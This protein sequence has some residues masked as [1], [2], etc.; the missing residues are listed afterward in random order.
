MTHEYPDD[1]TFTKSEIEDILNNTV[2]KTLIEV[3]SRNVFERTKAHPKI[4]GIA[5][6]VIERSVLGYRSNSKKA[7]DILIDG[8][9]T[10][11]K[12]TGIVIDPESKGKKEM[13]IA[14]EPM[15]ITAVSLKTIGSQEFLSSPFYEKIDHMLIVYY[16]YTS[17]P[18]G[19]TQ[20]SDYADFP[21]KGY[22][23]HEFGD[24]DIRKIEH[25]WT[26][27]RDF[28]RTIDETCEN[29][30]E[31]YPRLSSELRGSLLCLDTAPKWP[32]PPRF[33]FK[34]AFVTDMVKQHFGG[35]RSE[36][37]LEDFR[38]MNELEALCHA[39]SERYRGMTI[40][41]LVNELN[42]NVNR[43]R[44]SVSEQIII[45]MLGGGV[46]KMRDVDILGRYSIVP[47]SIVLNPNGGST[48]STKL[49]SIDFD[50]FL[51][52]HTQFQDSEVFD[53]FI[54]NSFLAIVFQE[55]EKDSL[56]DS[57]FLGFKKIVFPMSFIKRQVRRTWKD[58]RRIV[59]NGHLRET[60]RRKKDGS[61]IINKNGTISTT[62]NFP[63]S[64]DHPVFIRGTGQDSSRKTEVLNGIRMY[65]QNIWIKG[66]TIIEFL[67]STEYL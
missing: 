38:S 5:G 7:P 66:K 21:I 44:K 52:K 11:V 36:E 28:I 31:E 33:R 67:D 26:L 10:E 45:K 15:T 20:A 27:I 4:T 47:F 18:L 59:W 22:E 39:T 65:R 13:F 24:D 23:L 56:L 12:V 29:P 30:E 9:E 54:N 61:L 25:D 50:E 60:E 14:K 2:G 49:M 35:C 57:R 46:T 8:V 63:K 55:T 17:N 37:D 64:R 32:N 16:L 51:D 19:K 3:D 58:T 40:R 53:Y 1:Q 6:D 43:A 41:E 62:L 34:R 42:V 48:E